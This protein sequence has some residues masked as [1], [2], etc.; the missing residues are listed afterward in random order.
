MNSTF[1]AHIDW[2]YLGMCG[3]ILDRKPGCLDWAYY[4]SADFP[5]DPG[6]WVISNGHLGI[7]GDAHYVSARLAELREAGALSEEGGVDICP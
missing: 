6:A 1:A 3:W 2:V 4:L 5:G 7:V